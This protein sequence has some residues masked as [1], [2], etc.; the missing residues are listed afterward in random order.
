VKGRRLP[1]WRLEL[2]RERAKRKFEFAHREYT[3]AQRELDDVDAELKLRRNE[4]RQRCLAS[5]YGDKH[6]G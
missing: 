4:E 1:L 6:N 3:K 5:N 2:D